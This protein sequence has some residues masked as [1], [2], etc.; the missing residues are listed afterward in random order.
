MRLGTGDDRPLAGGLCVREGGLATPTVHLRPRTPSPLERFK[1]GG[2]VAGEPRPAPSA[3]QARLRLA[4][5]ACLSDIL[6]GT[7]RQNLRQHQL[8]VYSDPS[9]GQGGGERLAA[10]GF[11]GLAPFGALL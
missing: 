9:E 7:Q 1:A 10:A 2:L 5:S 4:R 6:E 3:V 8:H 11:R